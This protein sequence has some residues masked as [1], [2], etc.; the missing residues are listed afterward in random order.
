MHGV[1]RQEVWLQVDGL[2]GSVPHRNGPPAR[3]PRCP[4]TREAPFVE[5]CDEHAVALSR[6]SAACNRT[7]SPYPAAPYP[8]CDLRRP[9]TLAPPAPTRLCLSGRCTFRTISATRTRRQARAKN[10]NVR[11]QTTWITTSTRA[12]TARAPAKSACASKVEPPADRVRNAKCQSFAQVSSCVRTVCSWLTNHFQESDLV[13]CARLHR[14]GSIATGSC[15]SEGQLNY[16]ASSGAASNAVSFGAAVA[17][18]HCTRCCRSLLA[19]F[20]FHPGLTTRLQCHLL[21]LWHRA[22]RPRTT[23]QLQ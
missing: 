15:L 20:P 2:E 5:Q 23:A 7:L 9:C 14:D 4:R 3:A 1:E 18:R 12:E 6:A 16:V 10:S 11:A 19:C 17:V 22:H 8:A 21:E 13:R